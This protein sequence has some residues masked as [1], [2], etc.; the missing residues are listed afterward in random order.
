MNSDGCGDASGLSRRQF[1][2]T[3]LLAGI[4]AGD[5]GPAA[6]A[7]A[8]PAPRAA[9]ASVRPNPRRLPNIIFLMD[10]QHRWDALGSVNP[11]VKTPALDR[12]ARQGISFRQ[13]VT[14]YPMCVPCRYSLMTGFYPSQ[15]GVRV[16]PAVIVDDQ[17]LPAPPLPE[18]LRRAGYQTAGFGKTHWNTGNRTPHPTTRGFEVRAIASGRKGGE[19]EEGALMWSDDDPQGVAVYARE[20][21]AKGP[22]GPGGQG[23][24]GY[25]GVTS[26]V[27]AGNHPDGWIAGQCLKF[28]DTGVDPNRPLFLYLSFLKPHAPLDIPGEFEKLYDINRIP[29]IPQPS[30]TEEPD[31]H[32]AALDAIRP[33]GEKAMYHQIDEELRATWEKLTPMERRRTTLRYW[34]NCSW[35]DSYFGQVL[36]K[37]ERMGRLDN[38]LVVY[39]A[40]HGEMLSERHFRFTKGSL[41]DCAIRV[42]LI[43]AG[44]AV[45]AGKRGTVD[46]RPAELVDVIPTI[47][48]AAAQPVNPSLPGLDLL[49][50]CRRPGAFTENHG[51]GDELPQSAPAYSWRKEDW[52]LI[53]F[54][55]GHVDDA[56]ERSTQAKGELYDLKNDP[57]EYHNLYADPGHREIRE[58]MKTELLMHLASVWAR[59]PRNDH[60]LRGAALTRPIRMKK[61]ASIT[62]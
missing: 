51:W 15:I 17:D 62:R 53:M 50:D 45:P 57:H 36:D 29:D 59:G 52:K 47:M 8:A 12:L 11:I 48:T 33:R 31:T 32:L 16:N 60:M 44:P 49:S 13:A 25:L 37:L 26:E 40:D 24:K 58:Q 23:V 38:A 19:Y 3:A 55:P 22:Y 28:L 43:V 35:L 4:L 6:G 7:S 54:V 61:A 41:Y 18:L 42:P 27:P 9:D 39:T 2:G 34:A 20:S 14:Q 5:P 30:W 21:R 46:N 10:D 56:E 1:L